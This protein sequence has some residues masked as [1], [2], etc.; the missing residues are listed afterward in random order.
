[1]FDVRSHAA[2][3]HVIS[4]GS[5][6]VMMATHILRFATQTYFTSEPQK[7]HVKAL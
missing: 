2:I 1:M 4:S 5:E 7:R 3:S 6:K